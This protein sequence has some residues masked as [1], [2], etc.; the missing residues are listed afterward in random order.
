MKGPIIL[1]FVLTFQFSFAQK[2][3]FSGYMAIQEESKLQWLSPANEDEPIVFNAKPVVYYQLHNSYEE[4]LDSAAHSAASLYLNFSS[5]FRMYSDRSTP[6]RTPSYRIFIGWQNSYTLG[7]QSLFTYL[8]E[9]GHYSNG[10]AGCAWN[11]LAQDQ[12]FPCTK[13]FRTINDDTDLSQL[14]NRTNGNFSTNLSK[15]GFRMEHKR[16]KPNSIYLNYDLIYTRY[17]AE[18]IGLIDYGGSGEQDV[19]I[20]GDGQINFGLSLSK[21]IFSSSDLV[22]RQE[23]AYLQNS[24]PSIDPWRYSAHLSFYP[25]NWYTAFTFFF[26][27]GHDNYNF[28]LVDSS[29]QFGVGLLWDLNRHHR[30]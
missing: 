6:L 16:K 7:E 2:S 22:L 4:L 5:E 10:Q 1:V 25:S 17:H 27:Q 26:V 11:N 13:V 24:H 30:Y 3:P 12:T 8:I 14:L 9:T 28:R 23:L 29:T 18:F 21:A 20:I 19:A 15:L